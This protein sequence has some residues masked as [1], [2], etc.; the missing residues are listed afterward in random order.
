LRSIGIVNS[1]SREA[2]SG[3]HYRERSKHWK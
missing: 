1:C 3:D 2:E